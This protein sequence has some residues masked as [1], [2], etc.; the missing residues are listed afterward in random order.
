MFL[1]HSDAAAV[2][3]GGFGTLDE[4]FEIL[5]LIQTGKANIIPVVLVEGLK[6]VY[7]RDWKKYIDHHLLVN[8]W[9]SPEDLHLFYIAKSVDDAVERVQKFYRRFHSSRY[10]R[11]KLVIRL[12]E[13]LTDRQVDELN[14]KFKALMA[15]GK[16]EKGGFSGRSGSLAIAAPH[17]SSYKP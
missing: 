11:D 16:I 2:F 8:G 14:E 4:L 13:E 6:G 12:N 17:L 15:E 1:T 5:T 7:W 9:I 3:P 10:V